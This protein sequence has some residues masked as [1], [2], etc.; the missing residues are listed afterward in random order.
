MAVSFI[1]GVIG[2]VISILV[3]TSPMKTMWRIVK[4]KSTEDFESLPYVCTLLSTSLWT[5]YGLIK[6]GGLL[7]STVNGAGAA[8]EAIYVAVYIIYAPKQRKKRTIR[9]VLLLDVAFFGIV[10]LVTFFAL[11]QNMRRSVIGILCVGLT[12]SMYASPLSVMRTVI[13][14][15]SVEFMPFFLSFFL[16]LNGGIWAAYAVLTKDPYV[17][18]PNGIG[19]FLGAAQ[20][21]VYMIYRNGKPKREEDQVDM[22]KEST[23]QGVDIEMGAANFD[24]VQYADH[25]GLTN[26]L[27]NGSSLPKQTVANQ[28]YSLQELVKCP[29][30]KS[31]KPSDY[32]N[33]SQ[34][35]V[36]H[37][38]AERDDENQVPQHAVHSQR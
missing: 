37:H 10:F 14:T 16:F 36:N 33:Q 7:I 20:L 9:L 2:N 8:L 13:V 34:Q 27:Q 12:L 15:K 19:F 6:P 30:V 11:H 26:F 23:K 35:V 25:K 31:E 28:Q 5:Y 29:S 4:K 24:S 3:F 1:L 22:Q 18:I 21:I 32:E 17:G 38:L